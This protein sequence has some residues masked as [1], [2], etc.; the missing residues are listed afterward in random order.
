MWNMTEL[1]ARPTGACDAY[2]D[3]TSAMQILLTPEGKHLYFY[4]ICRQRG[5]FIWD[6]DLEQ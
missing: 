5:T 4:L 3:R 1:E 2:V 6:L